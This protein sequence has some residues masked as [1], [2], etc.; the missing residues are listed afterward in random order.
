MGKMVSI[1]TIEV[2]NYYY[3]SDPKD[4]CV[5]EKKIKD[6][7]TKNNPHIACIGSMIS[8]PLTEAVDVCAGTA[9]K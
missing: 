9:K 6:V 4:T 1:P 8:I 3:P 5:E 7:P 2:I